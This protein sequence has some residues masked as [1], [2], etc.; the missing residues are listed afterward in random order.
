MAEV[1]FIDINSVKELSLID[2]NVDNKLL[3]PTLTMVQDI[4]LQK[5]LGTPLFDDLKTKIT[6]D[7]TLAAY[8]NHLALMQNYVKK[9]LI[10]YVCMNSIYALRF[11]MMNKG[12]MVKSGENSSAADYLE[13]KVLKDEFRMTAESYAEL[14]TRYLKENTTTFPLYDDISETGM[15]AADTNYT[16]GIDLS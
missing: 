5:I 16:T 4:Y 6:A 10:Y 8:P 15:N 3:L 14:L 9:V 7:P 1:Y 12:V 11:R 13:L 2:E